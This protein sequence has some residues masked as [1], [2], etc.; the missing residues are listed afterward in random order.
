MAILFVH[1][2]VEDYPKWRKVF[3]EVTATRTGYGETGQQ[4]FR[5]A[6]DPNDVVI[7]TTWPSAEKARGYAQSPELRQGMQDA[8][9]TSQPTVLFLEEA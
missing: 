4:V 9:V 1:H 6:G 8:G 7:L 2:K 3:D 5:V